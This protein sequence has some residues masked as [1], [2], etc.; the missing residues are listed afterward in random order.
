MMT[1]NCS[2]RLKSSPESA[3][4]RFPLHPLSPPVPSFSTKA[5]LFPF[6][7]PR[8]L[9][10]I[11]S[12]LHSL[13]VQVSLGHLVFNCRLRPHFETRL[14]FQSLPFAMVH[15]LHFPGTTMDGLRS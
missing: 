10:F 13:L 7:G 4:P 2:R 1:F 8:F 5:F 3:S 14:S 9:L 15:I 11:Q 12:S 6:S